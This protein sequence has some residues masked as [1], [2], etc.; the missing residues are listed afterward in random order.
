MGFMRRILGTPTQ[1]SE[2]P[3]TPELPE[4]PTPASVPRAA[5]PGA[6]ILVAA[7][8][9]FCGTT[10]DPLPERAGKRKCPSCLQLAYVARVDDVGYIVSDATSA[11][12]PAV[13]DDAEAAAHDRLFMGKD[14]APLQDVNRARLAR[15]E[16]L[17]L[18]VTIEGNGECKPCRRDVGR[19]MPVR[20]APLLPRRDCT[21]AP[22][23]ICAC[24][25]RP[26]LP[27]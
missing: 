15:W 5:K 18:W 26:A 20:A 3:G 1:A 27:G 8:C 6:L 23:G 19:T 17:G 24:W 16:S 10:F 4:R 11:P 21:A 13:S 25:Y 22:T 2:S 7:D 9:P 14:G 12:L